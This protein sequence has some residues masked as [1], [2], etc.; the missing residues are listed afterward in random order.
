MKCKPISNRHVTIS[1]SATKFSCT[2]SSIIDKKKN[3]NLRLGT[4]YQSNTVTIIKEVGK[5]RVTAKQC[6]MTQAFV[7]IQKIQEIPQSRTIS[8]QQCG[9]SDFPLRCS[10][11][12][13]QIDISNIRN[14]VK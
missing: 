9:N 6:C 11:C 7:K 13:T 12:L 1:N 3:Q 14:M 5:G 10:N 8:I 4:H 2:V